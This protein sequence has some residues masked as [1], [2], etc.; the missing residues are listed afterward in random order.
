MTREVELVDTGG[1]ASGSEAYFIPLW[2]EMHDG[3]NYSSL[4]AYMSRSEENYLFNINV[5][6]EKEK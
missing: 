6:L 2:M 3:T 1:F 4:E 5:K